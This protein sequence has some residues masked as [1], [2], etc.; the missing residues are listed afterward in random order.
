MKTIKNSFVILILISGLLIVGCS[1]DNTTEKTAPQLPPESSFV[2]D[3]EGF[4][5]PNDTITSRSIATYQNW[6]Y[7]Y[8]NVLVWSVYLKV[9]L[10]VPVASFAE[11][12][13]HDAV[14][15][16]DQDN[17]TWS[18]NFV[19]DGI[20]HE[21]ELTGF[22][23]SDTINWEMRITKNNFYTDFLWYYG[24]SAYDRS[25]GFW[26]LKE[27]PENPNNILQIDWA[28]DG[29]NI[30]DIQYTNIKPGAPGNG[31]FIHYGTV[32]GDLDRFYNIN[33]SELNNLI[34][35]EWNHTE[36]HGRVKDAIHF[37]DSEWHCWDNTLQDVVCP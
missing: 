24:K 36:V 7:S 4:E 33:N 14:Y 1:K 18:Y 37:F 32:A 12:F 31:S 16:P 21:A 2:M 19:V 8:I 26:V 15:H 9:G 10:A 11:S 3:F 22:F 30:G 35:I 25:G 29:N 13:K 6:G 17:W 5:N 23:Q 27:N 34:S 28:Y 20:T